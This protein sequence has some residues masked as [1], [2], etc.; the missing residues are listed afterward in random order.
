L[1][2]FEKGQYELAIADFDKTGTLAPNNQQALFA[3]G[4]SHLMEAQ[5]SAAA[6]DFRRTI[7]TDPKSV[8]SVYAALWLHLAESQLQTDDA[9][10]LGLAAK[11]TDLS[12]WPGPVL[13][14]D[15]REATDADVTAAAANAGAA[16]QKKETCEANFYIGEDANL[17][18]QRDPAIARLKAAQDGCAKDSVEYRAAVAELRRLESESL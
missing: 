2:Y 9:A 10:E 15:L 7:A 13:K 14:M 16:M 17:N 3:R 4:C 6:E 18:Q 1:A 12:Q 8:T 11:A 5:A